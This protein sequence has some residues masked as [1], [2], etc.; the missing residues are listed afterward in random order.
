MRRNHLGARDETSA[1]RA[2]QES[3]PRF[4][5]GSAPRPA[6]GPASPRGEAAADRPRRARPADGDGE[7]GGVGLPGAHR[8]PQLSGL[9]IDPDGYAW[10]LPAQDSAN[11]PGGGVKVVR[12]ALSTGAA[13]R[14][15]VPAFPAAFG[16]PGNFYARKNNRQTGEA[17]VVRY[18]RGRV[19]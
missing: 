14:D 8:R 15:T 3:V 10:L 12:I 5:H 17:V 18:R 13:E 11:V 1:P 16:A 19:I 6:P 2:L 7:Q 9:V 4:E